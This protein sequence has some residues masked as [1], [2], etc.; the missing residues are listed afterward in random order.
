MLSLFIATA[1]AQVGGTITRGISTDDMQITTTSVETNKV[2]SNS[3]DFLKAEGKTCEVATDGCNS[4]QIWNGQLGAMTMMYC[5]DI[6][7]E[8]KQE[9][10]SCVKEVGKLSQND[11]GFYD[12]IHTKLDTNAQNQVKNLVA[13]YK[14]ALA[15]LPSEK[16]TQVNQKALEKVE[17][18]I[19]N[20]LMKYPQDIAL[21]NK[22]NRQYLALSLLKFE[23][24]LIK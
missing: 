10:W 21:P 23:L 1:N 2:Y 12:S 13:E 15:K 24:M 19:Y 16:Q 18:A 20:L 7:G 22:V 5:E 4:V 3:L 11:Q 8:G 17:T 14:K 6:Y 9:K